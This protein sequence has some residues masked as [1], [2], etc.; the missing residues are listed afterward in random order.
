MPPL[1]TGFMGIMGRA[2]RPS[3]LCVNF[4]CF[5]HFLPQSVQYSLTLPVKVGECCF[6]IPEFIGK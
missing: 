3:L 2:N 6:I 5:V 1:L 4:P